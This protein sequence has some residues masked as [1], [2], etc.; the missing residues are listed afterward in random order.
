VVRSIFQGN[1]CASIGW[2]LP[3]T[4]ALEIIFGSKNGIGETSSNDAESIYAIEKSSVEQ[5]G[6]MEKIFGGDRAVLFA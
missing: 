1:S 3:S 6:A 5:S 2:P 4:I